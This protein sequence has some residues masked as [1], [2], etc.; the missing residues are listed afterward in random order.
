M[1]SLTCW[2]I[3]SLLALSTLPVIKV[4]ACSCVLTHPQTHFC[5][6]DYVAVVR[7]KKFF[8]INEDEVAYRVKVNR[9]FKTNPKADM[10]MKQNILWTSSISSMCGVYLNLGETYVISARIISGKPSISI[11]GLATRW[12]EV[13][14]RQRKGFRQFYHRGCVCEILYTHWWRKG[15]AFESAAGKRCLWESAPGPQDCQEKYGICMLSPGGCSWVPS[16]P[17]KNCIKQH[18]RQREQ[19]RAREP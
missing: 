10:A 12:S 15:A 9:V 13:T 16:V 19:Q 5:D 17:Y 14:P 4:E 2:T 3:F 1:R 6:S 7:V 8:P 18:Q 11:C